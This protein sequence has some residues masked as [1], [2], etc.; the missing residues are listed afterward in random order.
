MLVWMLMLLFILV[1]S[2]VVIVLTP[3]IFLATLAL[4]FYV[5]A[6]SEDTC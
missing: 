3:F 4:G 5:I 1:F 2:G 6:F